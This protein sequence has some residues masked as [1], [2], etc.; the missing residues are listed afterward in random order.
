MGKLRLD[1]KSRKSV[2]L[3]PPSHLAVLFVSKSDI[4]ETH[5]FNLLKHSA[6]HGIN[7]VSFYDPW[8]ILASKKTTFLADAE[9][10][11]K[12][13]NTAVSIV[14]DFAPPAAGTATKYLHLSI[15]GPDSGKS[16]L[17]DACRKL[18]HNPNPITTADI[19]AEL[20]ENSIFEPDFV[21]KVGNLS[22]LAG[23]PPWSLRVSEIYNI[24]A[25]PTII[26]GDY[27]GSLM[28]EYDKRD[29]RIGR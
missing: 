19:D 17:V 26:S 29:R 24:K 22:T 11:F 12:E 23:Y 5:L 6:A 20:A 25:L 1:E 4:N 15:L 10:Y 9:A 2:K 8:G 27:F 13:N 3:V 21:L 14:L 28:A 7:H 18:S 16:S